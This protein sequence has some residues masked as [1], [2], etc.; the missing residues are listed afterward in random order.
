MRNKWVLGISGLG[1]EGKVA[2]SDL[3]SGARLFVGCGFLD[4]CQLSTGK[5]IPNLRFSWYS[6]TL[7]TFS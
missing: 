3:F 2:R 5:G 7:Y 1:S 6:E 4:R